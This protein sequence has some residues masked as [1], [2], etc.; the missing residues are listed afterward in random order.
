[1]LCVKKVLTVNFLHSQGQTNLSFPLRQVHAA[2]RLDDCLGSK[3]SNWDENYEIRI[4]S[5]VA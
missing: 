4:K 3:L 5:N 2:E 1:M